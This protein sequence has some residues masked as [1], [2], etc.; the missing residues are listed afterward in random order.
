MVLAGVGVVWYAIGRFC[1]HGRTSTITP[2]TIC[3]IPLGC[4]DPATHLEVTRWQKRTDTYAG[5]QLP[6]IPFSNTSHLVSGLVIGNYAGGF[7]VDGDGSVTVY[8]VS[9]ARAL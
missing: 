7:R 8:A 1:R 4:T 6:R 5:H 3:D 9:V 2:A